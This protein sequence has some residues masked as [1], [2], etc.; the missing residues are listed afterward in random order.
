MLSAYPNDPAR[1]AP[2]DGRNTT[3]GEPSQYKRLSAID[4]DSTYTTAWLDYLSAF[5]SHSSRSKV[6]GLLFQEPIPGTSEAMGVQHGSDLAFYFPTLLPDND[7]RKFG[8]TSVV[9]A[10]HTSL[11]HFVHCGYPAAQEDGDKWSLYNEAQGSTQVTSIGGRGNE[12][13]R[14]IA[15][16]YRSGFDVI[17]LYFRP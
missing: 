7:P 13:I 3:Y 15:P 10:L 1:G 2:F 9:D 6:W 12:S 17:R 8:K 16:P 11:I 5:S 4:T 14:T